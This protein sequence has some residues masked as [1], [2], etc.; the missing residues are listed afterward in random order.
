[1]AKVAKNIRQFRKDKGITQE[2]LAEKLNVTRQAVSNWENDKTQPDID[3]LERLSEIFEVRIEELIYGKNK[4]TQDENDKTRQK[5]IMKIL[6]SVFGSLFTGVGLVLLFVFFWVDFPLP[7]KTAFCII[8]VISGQAFAVFVYIKKKSSTVWSESAAVIWCVGVIATIALINSVYD[9]HYGYENYLII[10]ALLCLPSI[11]VFNA[12]APIAP[13]FY[14]ILHWSVFS[15]N[16]IVGLILLVLGGLYLLYNKSR[17]NEQKV[18]FAFWLSV[19]ATVIFIFFAMMMFDTSP[20]TVMIAVF[21]FL[22]AVSKE[23]PDRTMPFYIPGLLG[24]AFFTVMMSSFDFVRNVIYY[25]GESNIMKIIMLAVCLLIIG[26]GVFIGRESYE[27]NIIKVLTTSFTALLIV[28]IFVWNFFGK[29]VPELYIYMSEYLNSTFNKVF[30]I[31]LFLPAVA[32][33]VCLIIGGV[34]KIRLIEVNLGIIMLF[35]ELV[36]ITIMFSDI[37]ILILS[38]V[39]IAFGAVLITVNCLMSKKKKDLIYADETD[40]EAENE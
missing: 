28:M 21:A 39:F 35:A 10:D 11:F 24:T 40:K 34:N 1:M 3:S 19:T 2:A 38:L 33:G 9:I 8:P 26:A 12:V 14:M 37:N 5:N 27:D 20:L 29:P 7:V 32:T 23:N 30:E 16:F 31:I 25:S 22:F 15:E 18:K 13:Y 17:L 4:F 36:Q 6:L